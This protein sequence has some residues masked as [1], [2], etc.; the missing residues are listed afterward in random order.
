MNSDNAKIIFKI[1]C[2]V[3]K[4]NCSL[5]LYNIKQTF[6]KYQTVFITTFIYMYNVDIQSWVGLFYVIKCNNQN[7]RT[8][9]QK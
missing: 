4:K 3:I 1:L 8:S 6:N 9:T 7:L 2:L 5:L